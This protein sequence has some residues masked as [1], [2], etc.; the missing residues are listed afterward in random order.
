MSI[1]DLEFRAVAAG[2]SHCVALNADGTVVAWG[3][4]RFGQTNVP[5]GLSDVVAIACHN[6]SNFTLALRA[7]GTVCAW[8]QDWGG[9]TTVPSG[10][11]NGKFLAAGDDLGLVIVD[12]DSSLPQVYPV[13]QTAYSGRQ[14][15]FTTLPGLVRPIG[16]QWLF[17]GVE[18]P[19]A[20]N[21]FLVRSGLLLS[22][23]GLYQVVVDTMA[24]PVTSTGGELR[25]I[26]GG[27]SIA[28]PPADQLS[29]QGGTVTLRV[30]VDGSAPLHY[31]WR[32]EDQD[33]L[34]AMGATLALTGLSP[35]QVGRY[36]V[37]VSNAWG[38]ATSASANLKLAQVWTWG[39]SNY[40]PQ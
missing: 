29:Y 19:G 40:R 24:G 28:T 31:Q 1:F 30:R 15:L 13:L 39:Q 32:L 26:E 7:D 33:L 36:C 12:E 17:N 2:F 21:A 4:N 16:H 18:I 5:P 22:D 3:D 23:A 20:T 35:A 8:G 14:T 25:V 9:V 34:G 27:P 10:L 11:K 38:S 37:T 6:R